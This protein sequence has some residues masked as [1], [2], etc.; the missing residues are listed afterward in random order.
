[1]AIKYINM[2]KY[3]FILLALTLVLSFS[4]CKKAP[5]YLYVD[6]LNDEPKISTVESEDDSDAY[7]KSFEKYSEA[8]FYPVFSEFEKTHRYIVE[9]EGESDA[10]ESPE[11][12]VAPPDNSEGGAIISTGD[13]VTNIDG[14][15]DEPMYEE[16]SKFNTPNFT[17]Y[18]I[19]DGSA[20]EVAQELLDNKITF[21]D[22]KK[23]TANSIEEVNLYD[24]N[25]DACV[26]ADRKVFD[27]LLAKLKTT[28][29]QID[30]EAAA[31]KA[32]EA[33]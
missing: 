24:K 12:E 2:K 17:L 16:L 22:F 13:D 5:M 26:N 9:N 14:M 25:F 10:C 20:R 32:E 31:K 19:T 3:H 29:A 28:I 23:K 30:K 7:L 4:S 33:K 1:M 27:K 11:G 15:G 21:D 18:K 8:R 6:N